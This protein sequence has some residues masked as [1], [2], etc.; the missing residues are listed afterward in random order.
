MPRMQRFLRILS[1]WFVLCAG[2]TALPTEASDPPRKPVLV[3]T[4]GP[5]VGELGDS[6]ATLMARLR[7]RN[8]LSV[9][10]MLHMDWEYPHLLSESAQAT[11]A[12]KI[13][14][15]QNK[16]V[17][18]M[19]PALDEEFVDMDSSDFPHLALAVNEPQ[20]RSLLNNRW[21]RAIQ[22]VGPD[23]E[24]DLGHSTEV[25]GADKVWWPS[26]NVI[27]G[28]QMMELAGEG[29]TIVI[30]DSGVY[31]PTLIDESRI[32]DGA[33]FNYLNFS[34]ATYMATMNCLCHPG[35]CLTERFLN[36][37]SP[38][39][40]QNN[41]ETRKV[42]GPGQRWVGI[43]SA[44]GRS[45][46][47]QG[48]EAGKPPQQDQYHTQ[49]EYYAAYN[50]GTHVATIAAA[51][52]PNTKGVAWKA[53]II[54]MQLGHH[55]V[56]WQAAGLGWQTWKGGPIVKV[57]FSS[58]G[59]RKALA[60][61]YELRNTYDIAAVN[62]S[63]GSGS[64]TNYC[65]GGDLFL[66]DR[67]NA[68]HSAGIAVVAATGNKGLDPDHEKS[69][70]QPACFSKAIAVGSTSLYLGNYREPDDYLSGFSQHALMVDLLAPG[71]EQPESAKGVLAGVPPSGTVRHAGTSMAAPHVAGAIAVLKGYKPDATVDQ[72]VTALK[73]TGQPI[74]HRWSIS[75]NRINLRSAIKF[76]ENGETNC[77]M[78][79]INRSSL[80]NDGEWLPRH[81][82]F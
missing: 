36:N 26:E 49:Q 78:P 63:L 14:A 72:L 13:R 9:N 77:N 52:S 76:L 44:C 41:W 15:L 66:K 62:L 20:L 45:R 71:G 4:Q 18:A 57:G 48:S 82:W 81:K 37:W 3:Y 54:R 75:R 67:V 43:V 40:T 55:L 39:R 5:L 34:C 25:I 50:H 10:V 70:Q 51:D 65:D 60:R 24:A 6:P 30:I 16:I 79:G 68:L 31:H 21:V 42:L 46:L 7:E 28:G 29:Q 64:F 35:D 53:N 33:C 69:I 27:R 32:V 12:V 73:C 56:D 80:R 23:Y 22:E 2:Y 74:Y 17:S 38:P 8:P 58:R 61:V 47:I 1:A 11:Q 19:K 59:L